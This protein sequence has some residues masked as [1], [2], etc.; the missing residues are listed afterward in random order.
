MDNVKTF[1]LRKP[2]ILY[3]FFLVCYF[4]IIHSFSLRK[5]PTFHDA[6]TGF[7]TNSSTREIPRM[8]RHYAD[9]GN[10]ADWLKQIFTSIRWET[11]GSFAKC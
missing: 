11:S 3:S 2:A 10:A 6:T 9:L 1:Y 7:P 8:T 4:K 5:Q